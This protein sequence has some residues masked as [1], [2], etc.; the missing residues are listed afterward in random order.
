MGKSLRLPHA[1][2]G[3]GRI[4][5]KGDEYSMLYDYFPVVE[6]CMASKCREVVVLL[7][8]VR[9]ADEMVGRR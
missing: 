2:I 8:G 9:A 4:A 1:G 6:L 7:L 5:A 3:C